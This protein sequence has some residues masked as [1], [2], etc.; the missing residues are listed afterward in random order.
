M[1]SKCLICVKYETHT[2]NRKWEIRVNQPMTESRI[3]KTETSSVECWYIQ[4]WRMWN[5]LNELRGIW[6]ISDASRSLP[7]WCCVSHWDISQ[8]QKL[9]DFSHSSSWLKFFY[10]IP[11][12]KVR[13][14]L[15]IAHFI[16]GSSSHSHS[17]VVLMCQT[18]TLWWMS[19]SK[20]WRQTRTG[21]LWPG[22][23]PAFIWQHIYCFHTS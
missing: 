12:H 1:S 22:S 20:Q 17:T 4:P 19:S 5:R 13:H 3:K 6:N 14:C 23:G 15:V 7:R 2:P 21:V 8:T 9:C 10:S 16:T 18:V 11:P